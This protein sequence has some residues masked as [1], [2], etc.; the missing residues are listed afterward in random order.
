MLSEGLN[1]KLQSTQLHS[2]EEDS[3]GLL[4]PTAQNDTIGAFTVKPIP[5]K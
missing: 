4:M 5:T 1:M 2:D 3:F